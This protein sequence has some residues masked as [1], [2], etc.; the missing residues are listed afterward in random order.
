MRAIGN[1]L[2]IIITVIIIIIIVIIISVT[3]KYYRF[4]LQSYHSH[5]QV[6]LLI[7]KIKFGILQ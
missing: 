2:Y 1:Q 3:F 4:F 7:S 5:L 6:Q